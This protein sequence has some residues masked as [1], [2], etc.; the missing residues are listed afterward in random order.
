MPTYISMLRGIN[1]SAQKKII[2]KEL[3][4]LHEDAGFQ[5]VQTYIQSGNVV[6]KSS[7]KSTSTLA[8]QIETFIKKHYGFD[9]AVIVL[10]PQEMQDTI[11][12]NPFQKQK[13]FDE[14]KMYVC[15]LNN[16]PN[17]ALVEKIKAV[18]YEADC[19]VID[20]K[21]I[22]LFVPGGYGNTKL[23]NNFFES[24]LKV[25]ATTRNWNTVNRLLEMAGGR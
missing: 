12:N 20:H 24:K 23:N 11:T 8:T 21:V 16:Q 9:V 19:F 3:K 10:T 6:F 22:Y 7:K 17:V 14:G 13:D 15:F 4:T 1:V 5:N 18:Q 2:M 25:T